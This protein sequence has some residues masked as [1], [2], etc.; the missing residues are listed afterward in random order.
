[1]LQYRRLRESAFRTQKSDFE[2]LLLGQACGHDFA[3]QPRDFFVAQRPLVA[4]ERLAQHVCFSFRAIEVDRPA[5]LGL[6][7]THLLRKP[8]ALVEQSV[9]SGVDGIDALSNMLEI[10]W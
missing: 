3:K 9:N 1:M 7:N 10:E 6:G 4:F 2:R 5:G 8:R